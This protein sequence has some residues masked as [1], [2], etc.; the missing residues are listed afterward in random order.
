MPLPVVAGA[1]VVGSSPSSVRP[2]C[3][4]CG[5]V[6]SSPS[7][8]RQHI[9]NV[10]V[11]T[12]EDQWHRCDVCGKKC[13]TKHYLINHKLQAHGIRQRQATGP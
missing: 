9:I 6:Y 8:L 11:Q 5:R 12:S 10:H 3:P 13:K 1:A 7:N 4:F 2:P